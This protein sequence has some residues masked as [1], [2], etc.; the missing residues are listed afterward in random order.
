MSNFD[1]TAQAADFDICIALSPAVAVILATQFTREHAIR[2][3]TTYGTKPEPGFVVG[4]NEPEI[5][6]R[7]QA[8]L[9]R[10]RLE[11]HG[12]GNSAFILDL[13]GMLATFDNADILA[14]EVGTFANEEL[15][16]R[17][18]NVPERDL[19]KIDVELKSL[20]CE[21]A[22]LFERVCKPTDSQRP[23]G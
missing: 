7:F 18:Y 12:P 1:A 9:K 21:A 14:S 10:D 13:L 23:V 19:A 3:L 15:K 5:A 2:S 4:P 17:W 6:V 22:K 16:A 8:G 20:A 11:L